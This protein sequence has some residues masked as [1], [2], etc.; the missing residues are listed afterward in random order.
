MLRMNKLSFLE[1]KIQKAKIKN[2]MHTTNNLVHTET[3]DIDTQVLKLE[4]N[5]TIE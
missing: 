5:E 3:L 4:L 1:P 2:N